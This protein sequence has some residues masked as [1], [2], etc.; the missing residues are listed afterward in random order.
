[1]SQTQ[2]TE[3]LSAKECFVTCLNVDGCNFVTYEPSTQN[4]WLKYNKTSISENGLIY[5]GYSLC[6]GDNFS[7]FN[8]SKF[9]KKIAFCQCRFPDLGMTQIAAL[10]IINF[11]SSVFS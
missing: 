8:Y 1:M 2:L 10:Q 3:I 9:D 5:G 6:I 7:F 11:L 4:C